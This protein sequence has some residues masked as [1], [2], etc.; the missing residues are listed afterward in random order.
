MP[1]KLRLAKLKP[2]HLLSMANYR[3]LVHR[4]GAL[5]IYSP[6]NEYGDCN[7]VNPQ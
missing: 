6:G 3:S 2:S 4:N 5:Y 7:E 1:A